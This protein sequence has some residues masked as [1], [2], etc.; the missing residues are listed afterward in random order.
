MVRDALEKFIVNIRMVRV[1]RILAVWKNDVG[2]TVAGV[3]PSQV[4]GLGCGDAG[5][6]YTEIGVSV[7]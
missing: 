6:R 7:F 4:V 5:L 3:F 2:Q 1:I